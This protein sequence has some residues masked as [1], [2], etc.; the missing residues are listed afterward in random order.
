EDKISS[1]YLRLFLPYGAGENFNYESNNFIDQ[2]I[3][4]NLALKTDV[5]Y[6]NSIISKHPEP[7]YFYY[8]R[9]FDESSS[10]SLKKD[11]SI[12]CSNFPDS[13]TTILPKDCGFRDWQKTALQKI[14]EEISRDIL[15]K[16]R[17]IKEFRF[18]FNCKKTGTCCRL[19]SSEFSYE[20]LKEKA[21][22]GDNFATQ[23]TSV[24]IPYD[25]IE[26]ARKIFPEYLDLVFHQ[27]DEGE[28]AYFYH[29]PHVTDNN[30]CSIYEFRPQICRD[31]PDNPLSILPS[32]CGFNEWKED[33]QVASMLLHALI[34]ILEFNIKKIEYALE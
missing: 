13:V 10:C 19:A 27:F 25:S 2:N 28:K 33:V 1:E 7:V 32:V 29:C 34:E 9:D 14:K 12:L 6:V 23:F 24:F 15:I 31:F 5:N 17:E 16:I 4:H 3:N 11:K 26:D 21:K 18:S 22:N 20:E 8:C 30:L